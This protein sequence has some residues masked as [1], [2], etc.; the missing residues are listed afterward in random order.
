V[1]DERN[2]PEAFSVLKEELRSYEPDL[3]TRPFL[4]A[5]SKSDL[6]LEGTEQDAQVKEW[7]AELTQL[8]GLEHIPLV[9]GVSGQGLEGLLDQIIAE[10][11]SPPSGIAKDEVAETK[12]FL[13]W[14]RDNHFT[15]LGYRGYRLERKGDQDY[16]K[17]DEKSGLGV[18]RNVLPESI[19][20]TKTP[21]PVSGRARPRMTA[22]TGRF[23]APA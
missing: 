1:E 21:S 4:V 23:S 12:A 22:L 15:F 13:A 20:R 5:L 19:K 16:S 9:S 3:L 7:R 11:D 14:V 17:I 18:L 6:V 2:P 8:S 10:L